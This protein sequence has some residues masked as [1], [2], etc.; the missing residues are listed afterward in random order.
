MTNPGWLTSTH[1]PLHLAAGAVL[2]WAACDDQPLRPGGYAETPDT[3]V[4]DVPNVCD[5]AER[6]FTPKCAGCHGEGGVFPE[7]TENGAQ[8]LVEST[9]QLYGDVALVVA[10]DLEGSLLYRKVSGTQTENEGA[11]MPIGAPLDETELNLIASWIEEG[12][13]MDCTAPAAGDGGSPP[14]TVSEDAGA[15]IPESDAGAAPPDGQNITICDVDA[16][17]FAPK[18]VSCHGPGAQAPDLSATGALSSLVEIEGAGGV[19]RVVPGDASASLLYQK[20]DGSAAGARMP[21]GGMASDSEME[22]VREWINQGATLDCSAPADAGPPTQGTDAGSEPPAEDAGDGSMQSMQ[23]AGGGTSQSSN[24]NICD[25]SAE[26]FAPKC[27][28][29]HAPGAQAP[30]LSST[31]ALSSL[32]GVT[33]AGGVVRVVPG[34]ASASLLYQKLDGSAA[35]SR[36]PLGGMATSYEMDLVRNWIDQGATLDCSAPGDGGTMTMMDAGSGNTLPPDSMPVCSSGRYWTDGNDGDPRMHPGR[37]CIN[38]H[39]ASAA[40]EDTPNLW[41]GGTVYPTVHEPDECLGA[42]GRDEYDGAFVRIVD[43]LGRTYDLDVNRSGNFM[44]HKSGNPFDM[45]FRASLHYDGRVREMYGEKHTG[46]CN[47]CHTVQ[48]ANYAPGRIYLP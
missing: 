35:G 10:G 29:C 6:V 18:C 8:A 16:V 20:L 43:A 5:V 3:P 31:G 38:C 30:D 7:L 21:L 33:G 13:S 1:W 4:P 17:L 44:L 9:S 46:D 19:V 41:V 36:M 45:P 27:A 15:S 22:I 11:V 48:G 28:S 32:V 23:D 2:L 26:L 39:T 34:D 42:D 24:I 40:D 47:S 12:A 37:A 14:T 25:V